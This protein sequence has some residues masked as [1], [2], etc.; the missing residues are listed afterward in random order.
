MSLKKGKSY[1]L[2]IT[3]KVGKATFKAS[4]KTVAT[5]SKNGNV[6]AKSKGKTV[7]TVKSNGITLRCN[8]TVK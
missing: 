1:T 7:V 4:N 5:V 3:G 8:V 6:K 2:K